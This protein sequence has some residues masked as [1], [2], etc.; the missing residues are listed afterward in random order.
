MM[1]ICFF[2]FFWEN[3]VLIK[4]V[5]NSINNVEF[6]DFGFVEGMLVSF[7]IIGGIL[8]LRCK[9]FFGDFFW[10]F[11]LVWNFFNL[12]FGGVFIKIVFFVVLCYSDWFQYDVVQCEYVKIN[13]NRLQ[14]YV[15]DLIL[16]MFLFW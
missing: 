8:R 3:N 16:V 13:W 7:N 2:C 6:F 15:E 4:V 12:M 10:L 11:N 14:F 9:I 5:V 1:V